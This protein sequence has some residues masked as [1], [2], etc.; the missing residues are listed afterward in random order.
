[1]SPEPRDAD[2]ANTVQLMRAA[3]AGER[4]AVLALVARF[5]RRLLARVELMMGRAAARAVEAEDLVQQ[6]ML[7]AIRAAERAPLRD[8]RDFLG[9]LVHIARNNIRDEVRRK[10]EVAFGDFAS[11]VL[12]ASPR[13]CDTPSGEAIQHEAQTL[14]ADAID[15]LAPDYRLVIE[16][17]N[18]E[19][20][21]FAR[22]AT[23]MGRSEKAVERLHAR[24]LVRLGMLLQE[25]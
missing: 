23:A 14:V 25:R 5:R 17:R 3:R 4:D 21:P 11:S 13:E 7:E 12:G 10:R 19:A 9:W 6:S 18:F 24:A 16:L 22:V 8:E 2:W 1:M 20:L 15:E